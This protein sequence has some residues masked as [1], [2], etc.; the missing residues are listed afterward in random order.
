MKSLPFFNFYPERFMSGVVHMD[1]TDQ[2]RY[3]RLLCHSWIMDGLPN[4]KKILKRL[5]G[6]D[7]SELVAEKFI[8]AEDGRLRNLRLEEERRKQL[9]YREST[10]ARAKLATAA[11]WQNH[12]RKNP[13]KPAPAKPKDEPLLRDVITY[14]VTIGASADCCESF[15]NTKD[16]E[17]WT[18][19]DG[20]KI[21]DWRIDFSQWA[22]RWKPRG[23]TGV[24]G[25]LPQGKG[26][27]A[28]SLTERLETLRAEKK[29]V[30]G[31]NSYKLLDAERRVRVDALNESIK[32]VK[33]KLTLLSK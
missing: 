25:T 31:F 2:I 26:E 15:F 9:A 18:T 3:L 30:M 23:G 17:G 20:K 16:A 13:P 29:Q 22:V 28:E 21:A 5:A 8:K 4:D 7:I 19:E 27:S 33:A 12:V 24:N 10:G 14:G 32:A 1:D 11:R 6:G